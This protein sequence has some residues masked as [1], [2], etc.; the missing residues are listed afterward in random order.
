MLVFITIS[1][2][3]LVVCTIHSYLPFGTSV[4]S[5]YH[6]KRAGGLLP[7]AWH[8]KRTDAFSL[9]STVDD[10]PKPFTDMYSGGTEKQKY[11]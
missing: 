2:Y 4:F 7:T 5:L 1:L 11:F 9:T 3:F 8:V 6:F 10:W